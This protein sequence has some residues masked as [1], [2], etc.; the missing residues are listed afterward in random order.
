[1][2]VMG[3]I[4]ANEGTLAAIFGTYPG[5]GIAVVGALVLA[6]ALLGEYGA[7][8]NN[9][10]LLLMVSGNGLLLA[11][12]RSTC[13]GTQYFLVTFSAF[14]AFVVMGAIATFDSTSVNDRLGRA[15]CAF[16]E[17]ASRGQEQ[18]NCCG[19]LCPNDRPAL[20]KCPGGL[21]PN[22]TVLACAA[23]ASGFS[24]P[25]ASNTPLPGCRE[26]LSS[27]LSAR[28]APAFA[29]AF[30]VGLVL[31]VGQ[32][33]ACKLLCKRSAGSVRKDSADVLKKA[34]AAAKADHG[35]WFE[36]AVDVA[37]ASAP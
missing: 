17:S 36:P 13:L 23:D 16:P 21:T 24:C 6:V 20:G 15:W 34:A 33:I 35:A 2:I 14:V 1:M 31:F 30:A 4:A 37:P 11:A 22:G 25:S 28:I 26:K 7:W 9:K 3:A 5:A 32:I 10:C 29:L 19:F 27:Y 12:R 18:F 8:V